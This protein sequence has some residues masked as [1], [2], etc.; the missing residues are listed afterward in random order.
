VSGAAESPK[1]L[2]VPD[3][4]FCAIAQGLDPTIEL[5]CEMPTWLAFFPDDPATLG[6]TLVIPRSHVRDFWSATAETAGDLA[7]GVLAVGQS[8]TSVLRPQGMNLI[9]SA[10]SAAEQSVFHAHLHVVPRWTDDRIGDIWPPK[11]P[12]SK[13]IKHEAADDIRASCRQLLGSRVGD[14]KA[15]D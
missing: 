1:P 3:C 8:V 14:S 13:R 7:V 4:P 5:I 11:L 6:H 10:G 9:S 2:Y 12:M 15:T